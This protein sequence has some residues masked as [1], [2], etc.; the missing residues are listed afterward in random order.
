MKAFQAWSSNSQALE[1]FSLC[2]HWL[3]FPAFTVSPF[4]HYYEL[5]FGFGSSPVNDD[6]CLSATL[7]ALGLYHAVNKCYNDFLLS[8]MMSS[9]SDCDNTPYSLGS[10]HSSV[11]TTGK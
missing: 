11:F 2:I 9:S 4:K 8:K 3:T 5:G 7:P 1:K 10:S 6:R